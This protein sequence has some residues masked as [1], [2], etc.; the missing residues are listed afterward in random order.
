[1]ADGAAAR[2][3]EAGEPSTR[4]E[5]RRAAER[6]RRAQRP[7]P[8]T[9]RAVT[10]W[11]GLT[12]LAVAASTGLWFLPARQSA[13]EGFWLAGNA[14]MM[15]GDTLLQATL[16]VLPW[17][18]GLVQQD[19][20][21]IPGDYWTTLA[22]TDLPE[23]YRGIFESRPGASAL[24]APVMAALGQPSLLLSA[25]AWCAVAALLVTALAAV[26]TRRPAVAHPGE[27]LTVLVAFLALP[28]GFWASRFLYE[29]PSIATTAAV[30]VT[31]A[32]AVQAGRRS[33]LWVVLLAPVSVVALS[34]NWAFATPAMATVAVGAALLLVRRRTQW[35]SRWAIAAVPA[36]LLATVVAWQVLLRV[37]GW[38]TYLD[39]VRSSL[40]GGFGA[41]DPP[42]LLGAWR[43]YVGTQVGLLV[44]DY[45]RFL[46]VVILALL[47]LAYLVRRTGW[48]A[49]FPL[50]F[51]TVAVVGWVLVPTAAEAPRI[52]APA[53]IPVA[54]ALGLFVHECTTRA[55]SRWT[56]HAAPGGSPR[57][58]AAS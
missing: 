18:L 20:P 35:A 5:R 24:L 48:N 14:A 33:V 22:W 17:W 30:C 40:T 36:V 15:L 27:A 29:G 12:A 44:T 7:G 1:M 54:V 11:G 53:W 42:D 16:R 25:I 45:V 52:F 4:A 21:L 37:Q 10:V 26:I 56:R 6:S 41:S 23:H 13:V 3:R 28:C 8:L 50:A 46:P 39:L 32:L 49:I 2:V 31:S 58:D 38:P 19:G 47:A 51:V 9:Q 34:V 55:A 57:V 43:D